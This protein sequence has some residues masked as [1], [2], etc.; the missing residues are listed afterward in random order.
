MGGKE[1]KEGREREKGMKG[2]R[3]G[4]KK[5]GRKERLLGKKGKKKYL[6]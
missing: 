6:L 5:E 1:N 3:K 4:G 2:E